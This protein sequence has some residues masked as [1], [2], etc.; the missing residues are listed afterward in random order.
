MPFRSSLAPCLEMAMNP[1]RQRA[2]VDVFR[3]RDYR[4]FLGAFYT[5]RKAHGFSYQAFANAAGLGARN[6]LKLVTDGKRNLSAPMAKRFA[7]ACGLSGDSAR[8]FETLVA[9][10]QATTDQ[11]RAELHEQLMT[12]ARFRSAQ[13]LD[14]THKD[15]YSAPYI[16]VVRELLAIPGFNASPENVAANLRPPLTREQAAHALDVLL[17]LG[18]IHTDEA[19]S[20]QQSSRAV[21]TPTDVTGQFYLRTFHAE[22]MQWATRAM[23]QV[24]AAERYI[25][26]L[27]L[28]ASAE[29]FELV[30]QRILDVRSEIKALCDADPAPSRIMQFNLQ[31][32][33]VSE[34]FSSVPLEDTPQTN[35]DLAR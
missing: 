32:F 31:W 24:P 18:L 29:T 35:Q 11:E 1:K 34:N 3:F 8:Y 23:E 15:Y 12:F 22:M 14:L 25:S 16:S 4:A 10:N 21:A 30:R 7:Q 26:A 5:A 9:F 19:G 20:L 13:R 2:T 6:Y 28:S 17:R 27:T 33:P